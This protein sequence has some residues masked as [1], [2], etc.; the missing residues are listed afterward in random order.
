MESDLE[1]NAAR[2]AVSLRVHGSWFLSLM[3]K[4]R[5]VVI[6][7]FVEVEVLGSQIVLASSLALTEMP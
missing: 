7:L 1:Y 3:Y 5:P 4:R 2:D 6:S